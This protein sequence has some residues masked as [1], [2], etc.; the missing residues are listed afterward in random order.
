MLLCFPIPA[1]QLSIDFP[2]KNSDSKQSGK[3]CDP[4]SSSSDTQM[5]QMLAF[6]DIIIFI[7]KK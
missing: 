7:N 3:L 4:N 2:E 1:D 6:F 5:K